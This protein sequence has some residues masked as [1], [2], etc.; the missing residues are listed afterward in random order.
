LA[1]IARRVLTPDDVQKILNKTNPNSDPNATRLTIHLARTSKQAAAMRRTL[2]LVPQAHKKAW[3][4][5]T[6]ELFELDDTLKSMHALWYIDYEIDWKLV[7]KNCKQ[8]HD[9]LSALHTRHKNAAMYERKLKTEKKFKQ[10]NGSVLHLGSHEVEFILPEN[11][12][13]IYEWGEQQR[14]CLSVYAKDHE[15]GKCTILEVKVD[16]VRY[17]LEIRGGQVRQFRGKCNI[18]PPENIRKI[19]T[20]YLEKEKITK[21][22]MS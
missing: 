19:V 17:H 15:E 22:D 5:S 6:T 18:S 12:G 7:P 20:N 8:A 3:L 2:K 14:H 13:Q 4:L 9:Y 16:G 11:I 1:H 21:P 10:I